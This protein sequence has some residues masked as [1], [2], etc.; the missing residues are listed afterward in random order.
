M[1]LI[2][3]GDFVTTGRG[4]EAVKNSTALSSEIIEILKNADFSIVNLEAPVAN[5]K[6]SPI[7][8]VG[9]HL[10]TFPEALKYLKS[11][12]VDVVTLANNHFYDYGQVGVIKTIETCEEFELLHVGGGRTEE[13]RQSI[14]YIE[15]DDTR[16]AILNYCESEFSVADGE[17][18]NPI[19]PI[20]IYRDLQLA[21]ENSDYRVVICHGGHEGYQLPS[22]RMK[23]WYHFFIEAGADIVCNHHQHCFS[24]IEQY[25]GGTIFYGLG[26]FFFDDHRPMRQRSDIWHFGYMV[27]LNIAKG[28][29]N[30]SVIPYKQ[31]VNDASTVLLDL[32]EKI[33]FEEE[34]SKFSSIINDDERL[35]S[36][37]NVMCKQQQRNFL[38]WFSPFTNRILMA[39]CRRKLIPS[40]I[41]QKKRLQLLNILRCEAHHDIAENILKNY[42][43]N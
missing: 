30:T 10:H 33:Q 28:K 29:I 5:A 26:N 19:D 18:S 41:N 8:K 16:V 36:T 34:F 1:K 20:R 32:D 39:L 11:C 23:D 7:R 27:S 3:C 42:G 14:L 25:Q 37:F 22:P 6:S 43:S 15:K 4:M 21:K 31:C 9:P 40:F 24:G 12:G 2:V 17:G 38:V 13:E 35:A